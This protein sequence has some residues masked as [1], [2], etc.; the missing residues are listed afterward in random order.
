MLPKALPRG[1]QF[2]PRGTQ[3]SGQ[4]GWLGGVDVIVLE[5][6]LRNGGQQTWVE[7]CLSIKS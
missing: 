3:S 5:E 2:H 7:F 4:T 6:L 1:M